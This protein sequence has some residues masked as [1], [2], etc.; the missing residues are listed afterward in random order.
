MKF[1]ETSYEEYIH[2]VDHYNLH[3]EMKTIYTSFPKRI[4]DVGNLIVYGPP[5]VGKYTQV[6]TIL[7]KYS[8]SDLK[9][10]KRITCQTEKQDLIYRISDIHYEIDM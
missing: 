5:G 8:Q 1:H 6:L 7:R 3:P 10:D 4:S 9:Y 2:A